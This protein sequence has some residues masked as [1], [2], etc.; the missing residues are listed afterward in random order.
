MNRLQ[1]NF[2]TVY[3]TK[4][5]PYNPVLI[6]L[7]WSDKFI[8]N[9]DFIKFLKFDDK[10]R[11]QEAKLNQYFDFLTVF[12][13]K[14]K[15]LK[16]ML[17]LNKLNQSLPLIHRQAAPDAQIFWQTPIQHDDDRL[18]LATERFFWFFPTHN[19]GSARHIL[20][21]DLQLKG[22]GRSPLALRTDYHHTWGGQYF[23]QALKGYI[24]SHILE[25][26]LPQGILT[27]PLISVET[28]ELENKRIHHSSNSLMFR[29]ADDLRITQIATK[30]DHEL[31]PTQQEVIQSLLNESRSKNFQELF[32]KLIFNYASMALLGLKHTSVTRENIMIKGSLMDYEDVEMYN[33]GENYQFQYILSAVLK[34]NSK[35]INVTDNNRKKIF[36]NATLYTSTF[37]LY[38]EA[39]ILSAHGLNFLG[40]KVN[41]DRAKLKKIFM[42]EI[43]QLA[44]EVFI[45]DKDLLKFISA[46]LDLVPGYDRDIQKYGHKPSSIKNFKH[47][48]KLETGKVTK[49]EQGVN[50]AMVHLQLDF[51]RI[52][53]KD[54]LL[55]AYSQQREQFYFLELT[56]R[57]FK[58]L[59][60]ELIDRLPNLDISIDLSSQIHEILTN[61]QI[62]FPFKKMEKK[63]LRQYGDLKK[64]NQEFQKQGIEILE[65]LVFR[66]KIDEKYGIERINYSEIKKFKRTEL[67]LLGVK[68]QLRTINKMHYFTQPGI[69]IKFK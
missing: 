42:R 26:A 15:N 4:E 7:R 17:D 37:H 56:Q 45:V 22:S 23:W 61:Q 10:K 13:K 34:K 63:I 25:G 1:I 47:D 68:T 53:F 32:Q 18:W 44:D 62:V 48:K 57:I 38:L 11:Y 19:L 30:F 58:K 2:Y 50:G 67:I 36:S 40:A 28:S 43:Q 9:A 5:A 49:I 69:L 52:K 64:I 27:T 6:D 8:N 39:I 24:I 51:P 35:P 16:T 55:E 60:I 33:L 3:P 59:E 29:D 65:Y 46:V 54:P 31:K 12:R 66:Q 41:S 20:L 21:K 14:N